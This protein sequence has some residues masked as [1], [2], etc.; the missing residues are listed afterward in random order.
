M[1]K[2][3]EFL[4]KIS[5]INIYVKLWIII[6]TVLIISYI[7]LF[8]NIENI[9]RKMIFPVSGI[10]FSQDI[11]MPDN[12][13]EINI[14]NSNWEKI[15]GIYLGNTEWK[16]VYYFHGNWAPL[17]YFYEEIEYIHSLG[18][19]VMAFDYPWYWKSTGIPNEESITK[20]SQNFYQHIQKNKNLLD[21]DILI[22]WVS[23]GTAA[24][25]NFAEWNNFDKIVLISPLSSIYEMATDKFGFAVQKLFFRKNSFTTI[26]TVRHFSQP[27]LI[28]HGNTDQVISYRQ[29]EAVYNNYWVENNKWNQK[30]FIELDNFGHNGIVSKYGKALEVKLLEFITSWKITS[31]SEI[32]TLTSEDIQE[33]EE[34][35]KK[36]KNIFWADLTTDI[37]LTKFVNSD[38]SFNDKAYIPENLTSFAWT[39]ISDWKWY[40]TL[41]AELLPELEVL[42][43]EFYKEFWAKL[44]INSS[45]RS[46]A[47]QAGI[48]ASGCPDN[49]CAKAWYSE[50]QSGLAFDI[51]SISNEQT[52][53]NNATLWKYYTWLDTHAHIYG[54][55]N[56]YQKGLEVDGYEIE[57]WHWRYVWVDLAT[58]LSE[59]DITIAEFYYSQKKND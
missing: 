46:Y 5:L 15:N 32:F 55:H 23:I 6:W 50:H 41:R 21:E 17:S 31:E 19:N 37:S 1:I 56:T 22:W 20:Y 52:W 4:N 33:W 53:K 26:D 38:V 45:Y 12:M 25:V 43:E 40:G 11:Q 47:Y 13:E 10:D 2:I 18:V 9:E 16:T 7:T 49:L 30:Y 44:L 36:Y 48:K 58:Y 39:Y 34:Q 27:A 24:A 28:I 8:F 35:S 59:N 42:A 3:K 14:I 57:P 54:F 29:W 51:F